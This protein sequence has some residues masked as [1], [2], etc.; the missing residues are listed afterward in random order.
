MIY[1]SLLISSSTTLS[2][3]SHFKKK[4][5]TQTAG[6]STLLL[7]SLEK[8]H[9][10]LYIKWEGSCRVR[11]KEFIIQKEKPPCR[12]ANWA[13]PQNT[14]SLKNYRRI[15]CPSVRHCKLW[16]KLMCMDSFLI[17]HS[18]WNIMI[19]SSRAQKWISSWSFVRM[20]TYMGCLKIRAAQ[21]ALCKKHMRSRFWYRSAWV[22]WRFTIGASCTETWKL[23]TFFW[24][25]KT[26]F[27]LEISV[28]LNRVIKSQLKKKKYS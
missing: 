1:T 22:Y 11:K 28:L 4:Y 13:K 18:Q 6:T 20:E 10:V 3:K 19:L 26:R 23:K 7:A 21:I 5:K 17:T 9:T 14:L 8:A 24:I 27:E 16:M 12:S 25:N 2:K 15:W